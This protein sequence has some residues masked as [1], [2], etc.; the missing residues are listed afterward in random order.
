M[1][2][3]LTSAGP[4]RLEG[5]ADFKR[6][7]L[8]VAPQL[9]T[10]PRA[11]VAPVADLDEGGHAWV[12]PD[13]VRAISP[14]AGRS[15][16]ETGFAAMMDFAAKH[17]WIDDQGRIRAHIEA[18]EGPPAVD[19]D[20]FRKA[21]RRFASGVCIVA[22]GEGEDRRGMTVSAF[23][24]VSADPPMV[25]V[26]LN[27]SASAH[28]KLTDSPSFSV[29]ILGAGQEE[30]AMLFAG[31]RD[32]YGAD[33]FD[34]SWSDHRLG[35][36]VLTDALHSIVCATEAQHVAGTH[37][38]LIGRVT[39]AAAGRGEAALVNYDGAMGAGIRAA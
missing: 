39:D 36:P 10:D 27:R 20:V 37:T 17:G 11:A 4:P 2:I 29:N 1:R 22:A 33:R 14:M 35:A 19:A 28:D 38:V 9:M 7:S 30:L 24:S 31:Q 12:R 32:L 25:L 8:A 15:D 5:P 6:F 18:F 13:A 16:W 23:S 3:V 34:G 26:C 21:M